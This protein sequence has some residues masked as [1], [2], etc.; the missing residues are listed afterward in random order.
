MRNVVVL[1]G[2]NL[3]LL[4][5]REPGIYGTFSLEELDAEVIAWGTELG[6]A[7][8]T[9]QTNHEGALIDRIHAAGDYADGIVINA[10]ALTHY[11]YALHDALTSVGLPA[12]EVHLSNVR[13]REP[14]RAHSVIAPACSYSIFGRGAAGYRD[15][16]RHLRWRALHP[17]LTV[18]YG[19]GE[20]H[21]ADLRV[22][23]GPGPHPVAVVIHGGF[24][25]DVWTRDLMDGIAVDLTRRGW[26]T[27]NIEYRRLGSG[28][29]WPH[30]VDDVADA[31]DH[32][33]LIGDEHDLDDGRVVSIGHSAGGH[34]A[35]WVAAR[36]RLTVGTS[37]AGPR[38]N[39]TAAVGLAAVADLAEA[40][41]LGLGGGA[42]EAFLRRTPDDGPER[43][44]NASPIELLPLGVKQVL[45]HGDEDDRVPVAMSEAY[46]GAAADAGDQVVYHELSGVGH[47]EI[48]DPDGE[49]W[50][51]TAAELAE[52]AEAPG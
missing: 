51:V 46:A 23:E 8:E 49:P 10:G 41:R 7:V 34:L 43:Y 30:T 50:R 31:V 1:N 26:A 15:A 38:T 21:V 25:G 39:V 45:I 36:S 13:A 37:G 6:M 48:L 18:H 20:E 3:N 5:T 27:W 40:H 29:G 2:P 11:S 12:V 16:L 52:V 28:G 14:W 35:L 19:P 42:V 47:F 17:A 9:F 33:Q 24:W 22:P 32:L 4:G 44:A